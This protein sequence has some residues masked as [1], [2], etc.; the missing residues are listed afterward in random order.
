[1]LA[2]RGT[3]S[4]GLFAAGLLTGCTIGEQYPPAVPV[5][6]EYR[7]PSPVAIPAP[8]PPPVVEHPAVQLLPTEE[9]WPL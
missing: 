4:Y 7:Q 5:A 6:E 2:M 9:E 1:M 8:P 3:L